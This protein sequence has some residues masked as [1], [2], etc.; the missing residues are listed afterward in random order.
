MHE[1]VVKNLQLFYEEDDAVLMV[2]SE[3]KRQDHMLCSIV[4]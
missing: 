2:V 4:I 3:V 1:I